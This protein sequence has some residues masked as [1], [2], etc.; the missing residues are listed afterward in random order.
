[1]FIQEIQDC[2]NIAYIILIQCVYQGNMHYEQ[3]DSNNLTIK[4]ALSGKSRNIAIHIT[5]KYLCLLY[6][7]ISTTF[8]VTLK[9]LS[10]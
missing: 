6:I 5:L 8:S 3:Y 9:T 10:L 7:R 4:I 1:M 2:R